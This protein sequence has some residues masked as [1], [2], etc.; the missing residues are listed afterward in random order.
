MRRALVRIALLVVLG[1]QALLLSAAEPSRKEKLAALSDEERA[2]LT[3]FVAPIIM[4]EEEKIFLDLKEPHERDRFQREFWARRERDGL[5]APLGP[6]YR[7]RYEEL[8]RLADEVYDGWRQDAGRIVLRYG[9]PADVHRVECDNVFRGLEIWTYGAGTISQGTRHFL[10]Y[11]AFM[12]GP[13][14]IWDT[15]VRNSEIFSP[16]SCRVT[17]EELYKDCPDAP[18]QLRATDKCGGST[19]S[20][21]CAVYKVWA[22]NQ[23]RQGSS[24][25]GFS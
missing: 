1:I 6:G 3:E 8:R 2:W 19:C 23:A 10:F 13:R 15:S 4:P 16:G 17:F 21:A 18:A 11:R 9:E 14:K 20:D 22:E 7:A 12:A 24:L 5:P 25:G